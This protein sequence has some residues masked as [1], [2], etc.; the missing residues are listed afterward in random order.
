LQLVLMLRCGHAG[1]GQFPAVLFNP[2]NLINPVNPTILEDFKNAFRRC[3]FS[4][5]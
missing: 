3:K 2:I 4:R 5:L 1:G